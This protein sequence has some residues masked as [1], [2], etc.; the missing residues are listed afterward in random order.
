MIAPQSPSNLKYKR[1]M[2]VEVNGD[3]YHF[4]VSDIHFEIDFELLGTN[5]NNVWIEFTN[6]AQYIAGTHETTPF[7]FVLCRNFHLIEDDMLVM[8]HV[9]MRYPKFR[10]ILCT[11]HM[12]YLPSSIKEIS[13]LVHLKKWCTELYGRSYMTYCDA[14]M[15]DYVLGDADEVIDL[16]KLREKLY[17][18]STF[19]F[20]LHQCMRHMFFTVVKSGRYH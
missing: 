9:Y 7:F 4:T 13:E 15:Q 12:S 17:Q 14:I 10:F 3:S 2:E 11:Q 8:F 5:S 18:L 20:D 19:N 6:N 16:F 1:K